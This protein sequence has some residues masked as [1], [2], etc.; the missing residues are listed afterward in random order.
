M[1]VLMIFWTRSKVGHAGHKLS[2]GQI[3]EK[4]CICSRGHIF[5][6]AVLKVG[7][8]VCLDDISND[9]ESG[10]CGVKKFRSPS[11][12]IEKHCVLS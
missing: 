8:F 6:P 2:S 4:P 5:S 3:L 12:I 7:Q 11:Q 9:F 1:F 10:P